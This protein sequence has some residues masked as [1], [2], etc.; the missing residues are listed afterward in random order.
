MKKALTIIVPLLIV[1]L[2]GSYF[3]NA[4][5]LQG[6]FG[7]KLG[8]SKTPVLTGTGAGSSSSVNKVLTV[9][10]TASTLSYAEADAEFMLGEF[11]VAWT[12][13]NPEQGGALGFEIATYDAK[14]NKVSFNSL[15][16]NMS[17]EVTSIETGKS[18]IQGVDNFA[19]YD[20]DANLL[21]GETYT[22]SLYGTPS[23]TAGIHFNATNIYITEL[24]FQSANGWLYFMANDNKSQNQYFKLSPSNTSYGMPLSTVDFK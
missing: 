13:T 20:L 24:G 14:G 9:A 1:V 21:P 6:R 5:S 23:G 7:S 16:K 17:I 11:S 18:T 3:L 22:I 19:Q 10:S 4:E 2:L 12:E 8:S 15:F